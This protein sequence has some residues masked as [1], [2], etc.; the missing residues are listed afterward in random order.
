MKPPHDLANE[1]KTIAAMISIYCRG[2]HGTKDD[3]C[4]ACGELMTYANARLDRCPFGEEK[5]KCSAC[6]VHCYKPEMRTRVQ[7]VMRYA[8]PRM[9]GRHPVL[10]ARHLMQGLGKPS[11]PPVK[12]KT[13]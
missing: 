9:L 3:L 7:E 8:G 5:P 12:G 13:I 6:P 4:E 10:A 1:R 2:T 11:P